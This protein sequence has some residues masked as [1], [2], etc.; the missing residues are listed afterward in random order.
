MFKTRVHGPN[1]R[2]CD[3][4]P[5]MSD[6]LR[7]FILLMAGW[8]N[9]DQQKIIDYLLEEIRCTGSISKAVDSDLLMKSGVG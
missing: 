6:Y 3:I 4:L 1:L 5:A 9:R 2:K 8:I 7:F